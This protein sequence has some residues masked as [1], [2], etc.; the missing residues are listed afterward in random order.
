MGA[1]RRGTPLHTFQGL[2]QNTSFVAEEDTD[3]GVSLQ[4]EE[5]C[6]GRR[7]TPGYCQDVDA[8]LCCLWPQ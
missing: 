4:S 2:S 3:L 6:Q 5:W 1:W 7:G 8:Q